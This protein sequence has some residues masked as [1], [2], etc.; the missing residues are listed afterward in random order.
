MDN[1]T[2]NQRMSRNFTQNNTIIRIFK[3]SD[4]IKQ[5]CKVSRIQTQPDEYTQS[6]EQNNTE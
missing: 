1:H 5:V 3:R 4:Q 6:Q 2:E